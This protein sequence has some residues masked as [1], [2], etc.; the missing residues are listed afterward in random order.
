MHEQ[1]QRIQ[2]IGG[3]FVEKH[4]NQSKSKKPQNRN[5]EV[6]FIIGFAT[7][8]FIRCLRSILIMLDNGISFDGFNLVR[9]LYENY[10]TVRYLYQHPE[11]VEVFSAQLGIILGTHQ[12]ATTK[13]GTP[14]QSRI[15]GNASGREIV[16]PSRWSMANALGTSERDLYNALYR[17]LSSFCHSEVTNFHYFITRS[18]FDYLSQDFAID[19]LL[20]SH[21]LSMI[22]LYCLRK[23]S[24]CWKYLK[25]D[26]L[27]G[28]EK[29]FFTLRLTEAYLRQTGGGSLPVIFETFLSIVATEDPLLTKVDALTSCLRTAE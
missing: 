21:L 13:A 20:S 19:V 26:L 10:L 1:L 14:I 4:F 9:S 18:G 6:E 11:S 2:I 29:A 5:D 7:I 8:N 16:I 27:V 15:V 24:P 22:L 17:T 25:Q 12:F 3:Y 23:K 28:M